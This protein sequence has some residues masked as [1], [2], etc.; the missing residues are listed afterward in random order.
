MLSS[1]G[2]LVFNPPQLSDRWRTRPA[3]P[4][5]DCAAS[6]DLSPDGGRLAIDRQTNRALELGQ[7]IEKK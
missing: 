4:A 1:K 2:I 7:K 3:S 6:Q 5:E